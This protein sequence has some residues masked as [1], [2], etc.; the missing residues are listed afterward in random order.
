MTSAFTDLGPLRSRALP[1]ASSA[2]GTIGHCA[3]EAL[4]LAFMLAACS[5]PGL[6]V[7]GAA[8]VSTLPVGRISSPDWSPTGDSIALISED[9]RS[10]GYLFVIDVAS[11]V[12]LRANIATGSQQYRATRSQQ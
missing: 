4:V 3:I 7:P 11:G 1:R 9:E 5:P 10:Y 2:R 8:L 12:S 6:K